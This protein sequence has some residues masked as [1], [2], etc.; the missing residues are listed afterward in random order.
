MMTKNFLKKAWTRLVEE[1]SFV[2]ACHQRPDGDTLGSA[3]ALAHV[4]RRMGKDV[5]VLSEDGVPDN[6]AF[7]P[8][9]E[10]VQTSTE[11]RNFDVGVL[12]DSEGL[13]RIGKAAEAVSN[14]K[15]TACIDHHVP[16]GEFGDI[17]V[18]DRSLSSTAEVMAELFHAADVK[19]DKTV[20]TQLLTGLI[21]DTGAFRFANTTA[22]TFEIAA[23]LQSLGAEPSSIS[24]EV[25]ESRPLRSA[26][27]L[28]RALTSLQTDESGQVVWARI[29]KNDLDEL[30]A[31][32]SDTDSI[33]NHV[34]AVKG[35]RVAILFRETKPNSI[36]ISL[37]SRD[38]ID[39]NQ[40]AKVFGGGG[41]VAAAGCHYEGSLC[42]AEKVV[43][44]EVLRWMES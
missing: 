27:L 13:K 34:T 20:A 3:L 37:R 33:V 14:A 36:R 22:R 16:N 28:G 6:Y 29:T 15:I 40:I 30:G 4:L 21:A 35:P 19:I 26:K 2:L 25:Y 5:V 43:V 1:H 42:D 32:D 23:H 24:R 10:D 12:V 41:H 11:R 31:T 38:G 18:T 9:S 7:M 39:V 8:D 17:R 44:A